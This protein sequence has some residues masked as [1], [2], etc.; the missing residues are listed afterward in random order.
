MIREHSRKRRCSQKRWTLA[1][2]GKRRGPRKPSP[3]PI[4]PSA[5]RN[6]V[7]FPPSWKR[8]LLKT[9]LF[10]RSWKG[11]P[12]EVARLPPS[13]QPEIAK[14]AQFPA[15]FEPEIAKTVRF[16]ASWKSKIAKTA[17]KAIATALYGNLGMLMSIY[18]A[19]PTTV[20]GF[21]DLDTLRQA[22]PAPSPSATPPV[23]P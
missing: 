8:Q 4:L 12:A 21:F 7:L 19:T 17:R 9:V 23:N 15:S 1:S 6:A 22:R 16:L 14:T 5:E 2:C 11:Q 20:T 10:L 3:V 13:F 18:Q